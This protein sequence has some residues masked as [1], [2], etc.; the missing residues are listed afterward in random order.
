VS[1]VRPLRSICWDEKV[2]KPHCILINGLLGSVPSTKQLFQRRVE[3]VVSRITTT[4]S[5]ARQGPPAFNLSRWRSRSHALLVVSVPATISKALA[6]S[7]WLRLDSGSAEGRQRRLRD[8]L[9]HG[10]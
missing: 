7:L 10:R 3:L 9:F 4:I 5:I 1:R 8:K 2:P 6:R